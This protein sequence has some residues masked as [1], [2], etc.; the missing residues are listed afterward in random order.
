MQ[1]SNQSCNTRNR[2]LPDT[3]KAQLVQH[4]EAADIGIEGTSLRL[5]LSLH[6]DIYSNYSVEVRRQITN[7]L[8]YWKNSPESYNFALHEFHLPS[9]FGSPSTARLNTANQD[10]EQ[11]LPVAGQTS[12]PR[13]R[14]S[15]M[16]PNADFYTV[17]KDPVLMREAIEGALPNGFEYDNV[18][19][20]DIF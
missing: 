1:Q 16:P 11:A 8:T 2:G 7:Q 5:L 15:N 4:I 19:K 18:G 14:L 10:Q 9:A 20:F 17:S 6:H 12:P 13:S 3:I